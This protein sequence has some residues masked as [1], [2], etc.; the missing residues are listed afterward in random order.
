MHLRLWDQVEPLVSHMPGPAGSGSRT[1]ST[2]DPNGLPDGLV[3]SFDL[4]GHPGLL[5]HRGQHI[6]KRP[7]VHLRRDPDSLEGLIDSDLQAALC[8]RG[9]DLTRECVRNFV[10]RS[11]FHR[12]VNKHMSEVG[13]YFQVAGTDAPRRRLGLAGNRCRHPGA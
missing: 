13:R 10:E 3:L 8:L 7:P 11:I 1:G 9:V 6:P 4:E 5:Y 12:E 2:P